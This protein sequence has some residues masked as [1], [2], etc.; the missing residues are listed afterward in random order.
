MIVTLI[1]DLVKSGSIMYGLTS[2]LGNWACT[3]VEMRDQNT[4]VAPFSFLIG[5][6][7][8]SVHRE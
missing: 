6:R 2:C 7:D 8:H 3:I 4:E 5:I 1:L